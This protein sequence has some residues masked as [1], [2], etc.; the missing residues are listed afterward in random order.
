MKGNW[1]KSR[2]WSARISMRRNYGGKRRIGDRRRGKKGSKTKEG[3]ENGPCKSS[4]RS[5][6]IS[7]RM[8]N[9]QRRK[10]NRNARRDG[11]G[12]R[13]D[14]V[15]KGSNFTNLS[16]LTHQ[17]TTSTGSSQS[18]GS[19]TWRMPSKTMQIDGQI[20]R[21]CLGLARTILSHTSISRCKKTEKVQ[22]SMTR[23]NQVEDESLGLSLTVSL[24][25]LG[26][27]T[28]HDEQ[29]DGN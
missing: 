24:N 28:S 22:Q 3:R 26:R 11:R 16:G 13:K 23:K 15:L 18:Q 6:R 27:R 12:S 17:K 29:R 20:L 1:L 19:A 25:A 8:S 10:R 5:V 4:K 9:L 7:L 2:S 14:G 21:R